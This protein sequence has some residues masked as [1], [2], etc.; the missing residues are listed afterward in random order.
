[1]DPLAI[2]RAQS[3][4]GFRTKRGHRGVVDVLS[5]KAHE[6]LLEQLC[7]LDDEDLVGGE[8]PI[9]EVILDEIEQYGDGIGHS[10]AHSSSRSGILSVTE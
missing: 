9:E 6:P 1:M 3:L 7:V 5:K 8:Y 10:Q 2:D 4:S